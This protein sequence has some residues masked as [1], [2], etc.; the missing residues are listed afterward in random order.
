MA[1]VGG[2]RRARFLGAAAVILC[3][4]GGF[5]A[6]DATATVM[7]HRIGPVLYQDWIVFYS[8]GTAIR[9]GM[10][11]LLYDG[12]RL[13]AFEA[14]LLGPWFTGPV[15]LHPFLYPPPFLLL[16]APLSLL[17]FPVSYVAF[18]VAT[19][20]ATVV[21]LARRSDSGGFD[22]PRG[23]VILSFIPA[24]NNALT[25]QDGFLSAALTIGGFRLFERRPVWAG[26][27][28]GAMSYK[29]QLFLLIPVALAAAR[30]W[31][32]LAA[33]LFAAA[34][35]AAASALL[36]GPQA[37]LLW[38][39]SA[40]A[41]RDPS[42]AQ[43]FRDTFLDGYGLYVVAR[44]FGTPDLVAKLVQ[45]AAI[46]LAAAAT[47]WAFAREARA[48]AKLAVLLAA[49]MVASPHL[50][51]YDMLLLDAAAVLLFTLGRGQ[52]G[53]A[54]FALF[55]GVWLLPA[56]RPS[57]AVASAMAPLVLFGTLGLALRRTAPER[58]APDYGMI[59]S[60]R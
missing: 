22:W 53:L 17:P 41:A 59:G 48:D 38:F 44:H 57:L 10:A 33:C 51:V 28:L 39:Q 15:T 20:V 4:V 14:S 37:W 7:I 25:G 12:R 24:C 13:T 29:P 49:V 6:W 43:W 35:L 52:I 1:E 16:L 5:L 3:C 21:A 23:L 31:R 9:E 60:S 32:A 47:W 11:A 30:A 26:A 34:V 42:Y 45:G 40:V 56:L 18:G 19:A 54:E 58:V 27:L 2:G 50:Q 8:A 55:A 46:G 36:F